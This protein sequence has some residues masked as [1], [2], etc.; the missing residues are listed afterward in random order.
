MFSIRFPRH[1]FGDVSG[2]DEHWRDIWKKT[3]IAASLTGYGPAWVTYGGIDASQPLT[4]RLVED[5]PLRGRVI[6]LEGRPIAGTSVKVSAP[7]ATKQEDLSEWIAGV[8]AGEVRGT[9]QRKAPL[10]AEP[11]V[12]GTPTAVTTDADGRFEIRGLGRERVVSLTF[13]GEKVA[14]R[15]AQAVTRDM[16]TL[17]QVI[18]VPPNEEK[19]P[20]FGATFTFSAEPAR[21]IEGI[22]KDAITGEPLP[23]VSVH[24][25]ALAGYPFSR[26]HDL[27]TTTDK[28]GRFRL[29]GMPK[30]AE[31]ELW[32]VPNDQ[33]PYFMRQVDVPDPAGL[34]PVGMEIEL[35][36][37]IWITGKVTDGATGAPVP[38]VRMLYLPFRTN[39][40]AQRTPE[41]H[42][43]IVPGD[44]R[45]VRFQSK[46]DGTYR[47]VGLPGRAIVGAESVLK[48]YQHGVGYSDISGPKYGNSDLFD[49]YRNPMMPG[50]KWPNMMKEINPPADTGPVM[51]DF[52][53]NPG[54]SM[55]IHVQDP[56]GKPITG[57]DVHGIS[58]RDPV[59]KTDDSELTVTNLGPDEERPILFRHLEKR[60]G[61]VVRIGPVEL[62]AGEITVKLH[63]GCL[64]CRAVAR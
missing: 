52:A 12:I 56:D 21:T 17:Q 22:V 44:A 39:E 47:I 41:F 51:L 59:E 57:L 2:F 4:L 60:I 48:S 26:H 9:V 42:P 30:G 64:C 8:K 50:P 13:A 58:S 46:A 25:R 49:T 27:K 3:Q 45:Q 35:H 31:N 61:R 14:C 1:P 7:Q 10:S 19:Q 32:V 11:R 37:G 28:N 62:A 53:L 18:S 33:Q 36:R 16:E 63:A 23:G 6:D 43:G 34:G 20:V 29:I 5:L 55:R 54:Q 15:K 40:F 38:T 24:S